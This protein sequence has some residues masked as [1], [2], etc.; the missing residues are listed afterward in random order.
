MVGPASP[1]NTGG[2]WPG[3]GPES[4]AVLKDGMIWHRRNVEEMDVHPA[5]CT[6]DPLSRKIGRD[7]GNGYR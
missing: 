7:M 5:L 3:F 1:L 2:F 6:L 4:V